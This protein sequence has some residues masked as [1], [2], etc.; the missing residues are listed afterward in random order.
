MLGKNTG[1][2]VLHAKSI[3]RLDCCDEDGRH[4][5]LPNKGRVD[6][7]RIDVEKLEQSSEHYSEGYELIS[8]FHII[9]RIT[10]LK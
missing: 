3:C 7:R 5:N 8:I 2:A 4:G 9:W 6:A 1:I 10:L